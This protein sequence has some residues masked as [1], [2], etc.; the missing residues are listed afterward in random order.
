MQKLEVLD[1]SYNKIGYV[2]QDAGTLFKRV[3]HIQGNFVRSPSLSGV[4]TAL[5]EV[6]TT[7]KTTVL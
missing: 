2:D 4:R 7:A 1:L 6:L 5:I 3:D